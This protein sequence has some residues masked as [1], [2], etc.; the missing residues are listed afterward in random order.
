MDEKIE[1]LKKQEQQLRQ[2]LQEMN[3]FISKK[4]Q[5]FMKDPGAPDSDVETDTETE[6][7]TDFYEED[8][9]RKTPDQLL[10]EKFNALKYPLEPEGTSFREVEVVGE[11]PELMDEATKS[12]KR[13]LTFVG[14]M[15]RGYLKRGHKHKKDRW[16]KMIRRLEG[17]LEFSNHEPVQDPKTDIGLGERSNS[18]TAHQGRVW[19]CISDLYKY[20]KNDPMLT[21]LSKELYDHFGSNP[22]EV[23]FYLLQLVS[24]FLEN[25]EN[26]KPLKA[27]LLDKCKEFVHFALQMYLVVGALCEGPKKWVNRC[28]KLRRILE[29]SIPSEDGEKPSVLEGPTAPESFSSLLEPESSRKEPKESLSTSPGGR[30]ENK[31]VMT[32]VMKDNSKDHFFTQVKFMYELVDISRKLGE[33]FNQPQSYTS[34]LHKELKQLK[35]IVDTGYA[36]MPTTDSGPAARPM[37][38]RV[39]RM[40]HEEAYPIPTYGRVL[41]YVVIEVIDIPLDCSKEVADQ[42]V[43]LKKEFNFSTGVKKEQ[44]EV[45][46]ENPFGELWAQKKKRI[47]NSSPF[48][49]L[50]HWNAQTF[51]VKHG[52]FVLQEQ[53]ALQLI[54]Q[55]QFIF[56][57]AKVPCKLMTYKIIALTSQSGLIQVVPDAL[58]IDK[59]KQ[60]DKQFSTL[61]NFFRRHFKESKSFDRARKNFVRSLAAYS[62]VCY[63]L[64]IKDRHNGNIMLDNEGHLFHI[65][66]GYLFSRTIKFEKAPFKL[67]EEYI[68]VMGGDNSK[69]FQ[70]YCGLCVQGF[71]ALRRQYEKILLLVEMTQ[72][73]GTAIPCLEK[74]DVIKH[75]RKRFHLE[76]DDN[77]CEEFIMNLI[78]EARDN[79]RTTIYDTYQRLLNDIY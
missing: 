71:L 44:P 5:S 25:K 55:F 8:I 60:K 79:W 20:R 68:E 18:G 78:Y 47:K 52:D 40:D 32:V 66:F 29:A 63:V 19:K 38:H 70:D 7:D 46:P 58:S 17:R 31:D 76:W 69:F 64:Q 14:G 65:D 13:S 56:D 30:I 11:L 50:P 42:Y 36:Y 3:D 53:F 77:Q 74:E 75:L 41:Y 61:R 48:G 9:L 2:T 33:K 62:I 16:V 26:T 72:S 57:E 6:T 45:D 27:F 59:L 73:Q 35:K 12:L 4:K 43:K 21:R 28:K 39:V 49:S 67:T 24:V 51:I 15:V 37:R 34:E 22:S 1:T 10:M 23:S 54:A